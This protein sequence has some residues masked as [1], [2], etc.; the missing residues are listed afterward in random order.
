MNTGMNKLR[1]L[2]TANALVLTIKCILEPLSTTEAFL[3]YGLGN[4]RGGKR[5]IPA[6]PVFRFFALFSPLSPS[7][8]GPE[9]ISAEMS[10]PDYFDSGL[11]PFLCLCNLVSLCILIDYR[12]KKIPHRKQVLPKSTPSLYRNSKK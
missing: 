9:G 1:Q 7:N 6:S 11:P 5:A 10:C 12:R 2:A 8:E 3:S 4:G